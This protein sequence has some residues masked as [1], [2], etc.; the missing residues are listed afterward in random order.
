MK[1]QEHAIKEI[2]AQYI[3]ESNPSMMSFNER[4]KWFENQRS[5]NPKFKLYP[6][7]RNRWYLT[8]W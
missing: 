1:L 8:L 4:K 7:K 2:V 6:R 3:N 5:I